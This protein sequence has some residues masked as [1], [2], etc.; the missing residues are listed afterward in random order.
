M[1]HCPVFALSAALLSFFSLPLFLLAS[2]HAQSPP[3][4]PKR[5]VTDTYHGVAVTDPYQWLE[6]AA[7][8]EVKA[9]SAAQNAHTRAYLDA[10]P[11]HAPL[12]ARITQIV[13]AQ[14]A[15]YYRL[16]HRPG[17]L[18][19]L[20]NQPP[21]QQP[22][23]VTRASVDD[24]GSE[25]VVLDPNL[26]NPSGT[27]A[28]DFYAPSLNGRYVAISLSENGSEDGAVS[29]FETATGKRL[30]DRVPRVS[31]PTA[32]GSVA[33]NAAGTGFWY[34]RYPQGSERP[35]ADVNFYQ[36]IYFHTLGTAASADTYALGKEFPRIAESEVDTSDDGKYTVAV[37][38][39]GDGGE[40]AHFVRGE[41]GRWRQ[42]TKFSDQAQDARIGPDDALYLLSRREAPRGKI[43]RLPLETPDLSTARVLLPEGKE[44]IQGFTPT[45][46]RL[47]V[48]FLDG[49]PT[50][51]RVYGLRRD[52]SATV[53]TEPISS[54]GAVVRLEGDRV[55]YSSTSYVTPPAWYAYD[56]DTR[57]NVKT[58]LAETSPVRFADVSVHRGFAV[59]KDGTQVPLTVLSKAGT[60]LD[61]TNPALLT[62]YGGY[63][64]N[65]SPSF[66]PLLRLWLDAGG[67]F[68]EANIRGGG[69]Y[70]DSWH[71]A[72][73]LTH[74][75]NVFD[76]FLACEQYLITQKYTSPAHLAIEGGSNG[77]LL[78]G[79]ALTQRPAQLRAVVSHV[80]IYD[81]LR[82]ELDPNGAFNVTE[83]GTV[84]NPAQF[85]ALY[86]YS[87]YHHVVDGTKY[88]AV[89]L[90]TG[91]N[92]GRVNPLN[93]RKM[94]ARLQAANVS[95]HP[96]LL[97]TTAKA[98]HGIGSSLDEI[99]AGETDRTAFLFDQLGMT[100]PP[101]APPA[102]GP[103]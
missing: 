62:G 64:I 28:I 93:S 60:V 80:G 84:Q 4:T 45:T 87:P 48:S 34:T 22:L 33:W 23:L 3:E 47:Y 92:D 49:G 14:S 44:A 42:I 83:F 38:K 56:P 52:R 29:V 12:Q 13:S 21:K 90:M 30:P 89:L 58:T 41:D 79:A 102:T 81:M 43:L 31:F 101:P 63:G 25:K 73:N 27:T 39:N 20:K 67:V 97:R 37:V 57:K 11:S 78:M 18:F 85:A 70:G 94:L 46:T 8:P 55:L 32:G 100:L 16:T 15:A 17:L 51:L 24:A 59:S 1:R 77:G 10:L 99:I 76:D 72:G 19:F 95:S 40:V 5:P 2:A 69:E 91:D 86:A 65:S 88:P 9:W 75:Q 35:A 98:G 53:P 6:N 26:L 68:A 66:N 74:K 103:R 82:V 54:V 96:I 36:Q 50:D 61:G 7:S 71:Q